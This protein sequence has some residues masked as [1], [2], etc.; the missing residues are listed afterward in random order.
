M[1]HSS[2]MTNLQHCRVEDNNPLILPFASQQVQQLRQVPFADTCLMLILNG[3]KQLHQ[4]DTRAFGAGQCLLIPAGTELTFTNQPAADGYLAWVIPLPAEALEDIAPGPVER[5]YRT[6]VAD[7]L[8]LTLLCQ[9]LQLPADFRL[10]PE[11]LR[12]RR[13]EIVRHL[14]QSGF[15]AT[16]RA[17]LLRQ[18]SNRVRRLLA[19]DLSRDWQV[20]EVCLQMAVSEST[21]RRKLDDEGTRFRDLLSELRLSH[22]LNLLQVSQQS[23][24]Q[25]ADACGYRS[26]SRFSERFRQRFGVAPSELRAQRDMNVTG[27]KERV[28]GAQ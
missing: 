24:Q 4:S 22:G 7:D 9:W 1:T 19:S 2:L 11:S 17:G 26:A 5:D 6:F 18:W 3:E 21:L 14:Q 12:L 25:I 8:L 23:I 10:Q 28:S 27:V 15:S 16:L 13:A 20:A